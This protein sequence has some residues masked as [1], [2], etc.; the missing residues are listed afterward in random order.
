MEER[1]ST[2]MKETKAA[3]SAAGY[4]M[5]ANM[6]QWRLVSSKLEDYCYEEYLYTVQSAPHLPTGASMRE[7]VLSA[8]SLGGVNTAG[9]QEW[10]SDLPCIRAANGWTA[11]ETLRQWTGE[12]PN[13]VDGTDMFNSCLSLETIPDELP[14]LVDGTNMFMSCSSFTNGPTSLPNLETGDGMFLEAFGM[15][16]WN[17]P[18]PSLVSGRGMFTGCNNLV[19]V[20]TRLDSLSSGTNMFFDCRLS[21]QSV[22]AIIESLPTL[23][24]AQSISLGML[25]LEYEGHEGVLEYDGGVL[26]RKPAYAALKQLAGERNWNLAEVFYDRIGPGAGQL[27]PS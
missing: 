6:A 27:Y 25:G 11:P 20:D 5:D 2:F 4:D 7:Y 15:H 1:V 9:L 12:L 17:T 13:L 22:Q 3:A 21:L 14:S 10:H 24:S 18:L 23:N 19:E 8:E 26:R 16:Q